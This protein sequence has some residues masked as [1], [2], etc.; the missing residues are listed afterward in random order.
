MTAL[1]FLARELLTWRGDPCLPFVTADMTDGC[2]HLLYYRSWKFRQLTAGQL[3]TGQ[4]VRFGKAGGTARPAQYKSHPLTGHCPP[5]KLS[6]A[7]CRAT[8][9]P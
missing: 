2:V 6:R 5:A 9:P 1:A 8:S 4:P 7:P 3:L